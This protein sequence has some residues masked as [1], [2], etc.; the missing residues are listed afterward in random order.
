MFFVVRKKFKTYKTNLNEK[1]RV[2]KKKNL[3]LLHKLNYVK[4]LLT[5]IKCVVFL[6]RINVQ[7]FEIEII[8]L[9]HL[10]FYF[11]ARK[12]TVTSIKK[13]VRF[14]YFNCIYY[15]IIDLKTQFDYSKLKT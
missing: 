7:N 1:N 11:I 8:L 3:L 2:S 13:F 10:F 5:I 4:N 9:L 15:T 12:N 6:L 14:Y